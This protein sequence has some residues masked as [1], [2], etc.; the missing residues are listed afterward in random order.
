MVA[1]VSVGQSTNL[2]G[3]QASIRFCSI[4]PAPGS[5]SSICSIIRS[6]PKRPIRS[7]RLRNKRPSAT[8]TGS[9]EERYESVT[10]CH[11]IRIEFWFSRSAAAPLPSHPAALDSHLGGFRPF[12]RLVLE[13]PTLGTGRPPIFRTLDSRLVLHPEGPALLPIAPL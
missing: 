6:A 3:T 4:S 13:R 10:N 8:C 12:L 2:T 7:A 5:R 11:Q 9:G 1:I